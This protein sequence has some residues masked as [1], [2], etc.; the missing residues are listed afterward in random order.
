[1]ENGHDIRVIKQFDTIAFLQDTWDHNQQ[2]QKYL[3]Q[4]IPQHCKCILDVGCG[5]GELTEKLSRYAHEIIAIDVSNNMVQEAQKRNA[6]EKVTYINIA[7]EKYLEET[8]KRFDVII[9]VAALHHMNEERILEAMK[10]KLT[11]KGKIVILD[12]V[13][14]ETVVEYVLSILATVVNP[15]IRFIMRGRI[16][17][18]KEERE[19]WAGHFQYDT[20]LTIKEVKKIVTR[21]LGKGKIKRHF[22]WRYSIV[23]NQGA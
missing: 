15:I 18:P 12:L 1:M 14:N 20:Y 8:D 17:I 22:F 6:H 13:K 21:A 4:N 5:T 10:A 9:S 11:K 19:A 2:Y 3:L 23:Y 16:G 7:A